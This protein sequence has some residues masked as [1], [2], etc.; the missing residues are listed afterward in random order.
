MAS[1][2]PA[3][4]V[5]GL[6]RA[7]SF[8]ITSLMNM[9]NLVRLKYVVDVVEEVRERV[10]KETGAEPRASLEEVLEDDDLRAVVVSSTTHAH[11]G[12]ILLALEKGKCVFT[13]KPISFDPAELKIVMTKA[14]KSKLPFMVGFQRRFDRNFATLRR[15]LRA[16]NIGGPRII[17]CSSRDNPEPPMAY[18]KVSGGIFHDMLCHDFDM[19]HFLTGELPESVYAVGH[20]YN[21]EIAAMDDAD[22]VVVTLRFASGLLATVDTSRIS[23]Y[24]YDQ[25]VEVFGETGMLTAENEREHT[26]VHAGP[27]GYTSAVAH[28]SFPQ[29][30][31]QAYRSEMDEFVAMVRED[32][33]PPAENLARHVLLERVAS[34]AEVSYKMGRP[35]TL[36]EFDAMRARGEV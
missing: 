33:A 2:K 23:A 7:G 35:I 9:G 18:L 27:H 8:H 26:V 10:A 19:L 34:A 21:P 20:T 22:T 14:E 1:E 31:P 5:V 25:R 3:F 24:G 4:A 12:Q 16:G 29:R 30:Y 32:R 17:R 13:E 36:K 15:M 6:G 28:H 11:Y